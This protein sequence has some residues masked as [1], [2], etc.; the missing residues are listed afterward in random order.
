MSDILLISGSPTAPSKSAA[1]LDHAQKIIQGR[2]LTATTISVRDFP[3]EDLIQ[4]KY[5]SPAFKEFQAALTIEPQYT[6][7]EE[8]MAGLLVERKEFEKAR[9]HYEHVLT[10]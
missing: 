8:R 6:K 3:A 5:D 2:G 9:G 4:A 7:A 10:I 1:L